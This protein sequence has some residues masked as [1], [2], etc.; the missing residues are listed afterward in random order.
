MN[1]FSSPPAEPES[2]YKDTMKY[3]C[4]KLNVKEKDHMKSLSCKTTAI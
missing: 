3:N 1:L 2:P 4:A